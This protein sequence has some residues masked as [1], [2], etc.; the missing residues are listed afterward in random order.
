M[1][2]KIKTKKVEKR[3]HV[4]YLQKAR[5]NLEAA[6]AA[7]ESRRFNAAAVSAVHC[8]ISAADA[9][10]V[11][12]SGERCASDKHEDASALIEATSFNPESKSRISKKFMAVIRM[13]NMAEYEERL[14]RGK[15]AVKAV[16]DAREMLENVEKVME[17]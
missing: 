5:E 7:L 9:L 14:V 17:V 15:E 16:A 8:V 2:K 10:C 6:S 1:T 11:A 3:M 13:K 12:S 4:N